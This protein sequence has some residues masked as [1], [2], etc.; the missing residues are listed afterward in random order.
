MS[1]NGDS[2]PCSGLASSDTGCS[3]S[4]SS[5]QVGSMRPSGAGLATV[6]S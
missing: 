1:P 3:P 4:G 6:S 2:E 5:G